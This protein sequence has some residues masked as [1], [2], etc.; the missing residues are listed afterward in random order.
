MKIRIVVD[1]NTLIDRYYVGEPAVCYYIEM[2]GKRILFDTG[3][4]D[5]FLANA[6]AMDIDLRSLTHI[7]LSHGHNAHTGGLAY[8]LKSDLPPWVRLVAHPG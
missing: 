2:N 3:Y 5:V 6:K 1:N 7:V 4:S 8:L